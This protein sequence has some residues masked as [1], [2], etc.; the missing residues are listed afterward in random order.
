MPYLPTN[1]YQVTEWIETQCMLHIN[2][3][4]VQPSWGRKEGL[5]NMGTDYNTHPLTF[6]YLVDYHILTVKRAMSNNTLALTF[7]KSASS[8]RR[9]QNLLW[10]KLSMAQ[11]YSA[12]LSCISRT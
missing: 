4:S 6:G 3:A 5:W 12:R 9:K 10:H 1:R 7:K 2:P 8:T 11:R